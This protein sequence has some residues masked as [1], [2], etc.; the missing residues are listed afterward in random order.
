MVKFK[1]L[2]I[3][4]RQSDLGGYVSGNR[5]D[6]RWPV[7][8]VSTVGPHSVHI[9]SLFPVDIGHQSVSDIAENIDL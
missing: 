9:S 4:Q 5:G 7:S 1:G 6:V 2:N 3:V 8:D